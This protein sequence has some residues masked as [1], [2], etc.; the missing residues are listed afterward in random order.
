MTSNLL[1]MKFHG[2]NEDNDHEKLLENYNYLSEKNCL[3]STRY[4]NHTPLT[5]RRSISL[6]DSSTDHK[7]KPFEKQKDSSNFLLPSY[8]PTLSSSLNSLCL[9]IRRHQLLT[10]H[11][12]NID[13]TTKENDFNWWKTIARLRPLFERIISEQ[14]PIDQFSSV[15]DQDD[16]KSFQ[17]QFQACLRKGRR[18]AICIAIDRL[19]YNEQLF[20]FASLANEVQLDFSLLLSSFKT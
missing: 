1:R 16:S 11:D 9:R 5:L 4:V 10:D 20:L 17:L 19:Y 6:E 7:G 14:N 3:K 12:E 13:Q 18:N 2:H 15:Y 8:N